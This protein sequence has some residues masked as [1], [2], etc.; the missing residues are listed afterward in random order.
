MQKGGW[1]WNYTSHLVPQNTP[2]DEGCF[3]RRHVTF[4]KWNILTQETGVTWSDL[5]AWPRLEDERIFATHRAQVRGA[6]LQQAALRLLRHMGLLSQNWSNGSLRRKTHASIFAHVGV[7][8]TGTRAC[9][10]RA[11]GSL[12]LASDTIHRTRCWRS[13]DGRCREY[14]SF[15]VYQTSITSTPAQPTPS[16]K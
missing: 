6:R 10:V 4:N 5:V 14:R 12:H 11:A 16:H 3:I 13:C 1:G 8:N 2:Q 9:S 15:Q 7:R